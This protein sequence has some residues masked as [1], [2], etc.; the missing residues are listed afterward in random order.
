MGVWDHAQAI[1]GV[2]AAALAVA[3]RIFQLDGPFLIIKNQNSFKK[4][5]QL[6]LRY[7]TKGR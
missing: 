1:D 5:S 7:I 3:A 4:P 6:S 2:L